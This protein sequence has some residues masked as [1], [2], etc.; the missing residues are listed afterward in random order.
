MRYRCTKSFQIEK[1]DDDGFFTEKYKT[2]KENSIWV[3]KADSYRLIDGEVRL[4]KYDKKSYSWVEIPKV[5]LDHYFEKIHERRLI[6]IDVLI[7]Q[8]ER[9][10]DCNYG[11]QLI[12]PR[13]FLD[14]VEEQDIVHYKK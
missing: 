13:Y 2:I 12:N 11:E 10:F 5:M 3:L 4:E 6:D 14:L 8:V 9:D 7:K 1:V